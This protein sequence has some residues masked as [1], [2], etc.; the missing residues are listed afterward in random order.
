MRPKALQIKTNTVAIFANKYI[1]SN[2]Q[3][4]VQASYAIMSTLWV[5]LVKLGLNSWTK[6]NLTW[7]NLN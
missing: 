2:T 6:R 5:S 4:W 1:Y 3:E 7:P